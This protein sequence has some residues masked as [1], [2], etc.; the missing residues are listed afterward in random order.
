MPTLR[1][2]D[3]LVALADTCHFRRAA[4]RT[5]TTQSTLSIQIK[6]LEDRLGAPLVTRA[7]NR[8]ALTAIGEDVVTVARRMLRDAQTI[9]DLGKG[10][11]KSS[12]VI[13]IGVAPFLSAGFLSHLKI[14][15]GN[16]RRSVRYAV[17]EESPQVLADQLSSNECDC[18]LS[19]LTLDDDAYGAEFLFDDEVVALIPSHH[20][21]AD[22][23]SLGWAELKGQTVF[24]CGRGDPFLKD[25]ARKCKDAGADVCL[26]YEMASPLTLSTL[27]ASGHGIAFASATYARAI[28]KDDG[29]V[30][31]RFFNDPGLIRP[32]SVSFR[33]DAFVEQHVELIVSAIKAVHANSGAALRQVRQL[34]HS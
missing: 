2:L 12:Q 21:L 15:Q 9:R 8:V 32:I 3:Y 33:R 14:A 34:S 27:V 22:L 6:A 19:P 10:Y 28:C 1:Q 7:P 18:I 30:S 13:R 5:H 24:L 26:D 23:Q 20:S 11:G 31:I 29:P 25:L 16:A 17:C 4:E